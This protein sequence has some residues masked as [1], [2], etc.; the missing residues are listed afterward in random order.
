MDFT[1]LN[2]QHS[3][4]N[5]PAF[6][7][8]KT[9]RIDLENPD[10]ASDGF[11]KQDFANKVAASVDHNA[12]D[13]HLCTGFHPVLRIDGELK[14]VTDWPKVTAGWL[15]GLRRHMLSDAQESQLQQQGQVDCA[16]TTVGRQRLRANIFQQQQGQSIAFRIIPAIC[17]SLTQLAVPPILNQLIQ[18]ENGLILVTGATG[19]GKST[20]LNA[21]ISAINQQ[22]ARH[23]ITLED[24]IEF[25]HNSQSCL[26]Q[27]RELGSHT[28][29][30]S[31]ALSGALRQDPDI[32]L[33]GELRGLETIRLAL[34]AAETGHLVL[35][36]LHTRTA[37]QAIDRLID[38]FPPE[39]KAV[40]RTQLAASLRGVITQKLC[41]QNGGGRIAVFEILTQTTAVSHL[42]REGK[43]YQLPTVI[44]AGGQWGMQTF[45]QSIAQRQKQGALA[46]SH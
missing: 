36:T 20:T 12:S 16:Y 40:I 5:N 28:H 46:L 14:T 17:P 9:K 33:L 32:I 18:Q 23:I 15:N 21:M 39:E 43:T 4:L 11:N 2:N 7:R 10:L 13:L 34:T 41:R 22:Q 27:Q 8:I 6:S 29:C 31:R 37:T 26:I 38:V 45:E 3:D 24:P 25:I 19:S 30:F 35:A 1:S 44:Q 42:I